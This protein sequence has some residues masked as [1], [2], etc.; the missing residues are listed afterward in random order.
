MLLFAFETVILTFLFHFSDLSDEDREHRLVVNYRVNERAIE[1]H[2]FFGIFEISDRSVRR[3]ERRFASASRRHIAL[4]RLFFIARRCGAWLSCGRCDRFCGGD[5]C[6]CHCLSDGRHRH[7]CHYPC[8]RCDC[9]GISWRQSIGIL[10]ARNTR[11]DRVGG[12]LLRSRFFDGTIIRAS[13]NGRKQDDR[14][15]CR[16][17]KMFFLQL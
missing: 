17:Y 4:R 12:C 16:Q 10:Y 11:H 8:G 9:R 1:H 13:A 2:T 7:I 5:R 14:R 15:K 6:V 3:H